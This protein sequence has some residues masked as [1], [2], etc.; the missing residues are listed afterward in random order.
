[1][2]ERA[3]WPRPRSIRALLSLGLVVPLVCLLALWGFGTD[4]TMTRAAA[5]H[6]FTAADQ[7]YSGPAQALSSA[8]AAEQ[9]QTVTWLS[10][11]RSGSLAPLHA[12]FEATD[13]A[14]AS[15]LTAARADQPVISSSAQPAL[16]SLE[17]LLAGRVPLR[18][19]ALA[20]R[21]TPLAAVA[22]YSA[23]ITGVNAFDAGLLVT[24]DA[25]LTRQAAAT[26]EANGGVDLGRSDIA[27]VSVAVAA[28]DSMSAPEREV[29]GADAAQAQLMMSG[30]VSVLTP[31]LGSGYVR[32][33][34]SGAFRALFTAEGAIG[35]RVTGAGVLPVSPSSFAA[36]A[37]ALNRDYQAAEQQ[38]VT[39][40]KSLAGQ[41]SSAATRATV[42]VAGLGLVA[43]LASIGLAI[44]LWWRIVRDLTRL[45]DTAL[46]MAADQLPEPRE[47]PS[48]SDA[49]HGSAPRVRW[50]AGSIR[51]I[52]RAGAALS[53]AQQLARQAATGQDQLRSGASQLLRNLGLRSH[54]VADRQIALLDVIERRSSDAQAR[55][56]LAAVGQLSTR[57]RRQADGLLVLSGGSL[58]SRDQAPVPIS[59]L[60]RAAMPEVDDGSRVTLVSDSL[61]AVTT[62]AV[63]DVL[64]LIAELVD[65]AVR[66]TP[67]LAEVIVR[68]GRVGRGLVVEVEDDGPGFDFESANTVLADPPDIG[69]AVGDGLG[70]LVV[71]RLAARRGIAVNFRSSPI[72]GTIAIVLLPHAILV[73]SEERDTIV[74]GSLPRIDVTMPAPDAPPQGQLA[75]TLPQRLAD[76]DAAQPARRV[77]PYLSTQPTATAPIVRIAESN[78]PWY[79]LTASQPARTPGPEPPGSAAD[80]TGGDARDPGT[81][82]PLPR[83]IRPAVPPSEGAVSATPPSPGPDQAAA[84]DAVGRDPDDSTEASPGTQPTGDG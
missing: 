67:Q 55:A 30:A 13:R 58:A 9:L 20:G 7:L 40:L 17:S 19:A 56:G 49:G 8:L 24:D 1:M 42:L 84:P 36:T 82:A 11:G 25:S 76:P 54:A 64:Y 31:T 72:R 80:V 45:Q 79:W 21:I 32:A 57:M 63:P 78:A 35:S 51:E 37:A 10:A 39:G 38:D 15:F 65:N 50:P 68:A 66:H 28:G 12:Q 53:A 77:A 47:G 52:A 46:T 71:S 61:D 73:A 44:L 83:R 6:D 26:V 74:D 23:I 43:V 60:I 69:P 2:P 18:T 22:A 81:A 59:D 41:A 5:V 33:T 27:L 75:P 4:V 29:F 16:H 62:D 34:S 3:R 70:L 14:A 48:G